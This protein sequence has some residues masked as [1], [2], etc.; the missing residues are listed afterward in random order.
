MD[1][2]SNHSDPIRALVECAECGAD[3]QVSG[4]TFAD[5]QKK[6]RNAQ[7]VIASDD[8]AEYLH[9]NCP[10]RSTARPTEDDDQ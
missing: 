3:I 9:R 8:D 4:A 5:I 1:R 6:L 10:A 2:L 7:N